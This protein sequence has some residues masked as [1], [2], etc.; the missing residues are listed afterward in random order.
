MFTLS[1]SL[2]KIKGKMRQF[3]YYNPAKPCIL[4]SSQ[5]YV[6]LNLYY[7]EINSALAWNLREYY[8]ETLKLNILNISNILRECITP[9]L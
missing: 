3:R 8:N 9:N 5:Y 4:K 7:T 6:L 1:I 2:K